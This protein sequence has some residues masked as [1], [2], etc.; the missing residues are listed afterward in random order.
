MRALT[1]S[2]RALRALKWADRG[3]GPG[4]GRTWRQPHGADHSEN[5]HCD[6]AAPMQT[7]HG[8][9]SVLHFIVLQ[10]FCTYKVLVVPF[11][12]DKSTSLPT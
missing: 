11:V 8:I 5:F 12:Q 3:P 6:G 10:Y 4:P 7:D 9:T 1:D 2:L